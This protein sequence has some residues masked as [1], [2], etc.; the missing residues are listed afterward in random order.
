MI[1]KSIRLNGTAG[2]FKTLIYSLSICCFFLSTTPLKA[3]CEASS[4]TL[5]TLISVPGSEGTA[6]MAAIADTAV[7]PD[8]AVQVFLLTKDSAQIITGFSKNPMFDVTPLGRYAIHSFVFDTTG[9]KLDTVDFGATTLLAL[10]QKLPDTLCFSLDTVGVSIE[11]PFNEI[12]CGADAGELVELDQSCLSD[13]T[14]L[15][16]AEHIFAPVVPEGFLKVY[17]LTS[18]STFK[19]RGFSNQ[20]FFLVE[21]E[22]K[23]NVHTLVY[24]TT[25]LS[26][27]SVLIGRT[28]LVEVFRWLK[29]GGGEACGDLDTEGIVFD[30]NECPCEAT[31][32][33]LAANEACL[34]N[35]LALL[36]ATVVDTP[37]VPEDFEVAYFLSSA[38]DGIIQAIS[39]TPTF[40]VNEPGEYTIHTFVH[41]Q[42]TFP[43]TAIVE[44]VTKISV[45]DMFLLQSGGFICAALDL[46]GATFAV[47][48]CTVELARPS[49]YPGSVVNTINVNIPATHMDRPMGINIYDLNGRKVLS[50]R[51]DAGVTQAQ[52]DASHLNQGMYAIQF[53]YN[54][55]VMLFQDLFF[56]E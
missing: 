35:G 6:I 9:F 1:P 7:V 12:T 54:N 36:E 39:D 31:F 3:Q 53:L 21:G 33:I 23:L 41:N 46:K 47:E 44:G 37:F 26:L 24:D 4:G 13:G 14:R 34:E 52:I 25:T 30:I 50:T 15:I 5:D 43:I 56:K 32:G 55:G 19:V 45:V 40:T 2:Q 18:G 8:S 16:E 28:G 29:V 42:A 27:D 51:I 11:F 10:P 20:P 38:P 22:G 48:D 17:L 49:Y